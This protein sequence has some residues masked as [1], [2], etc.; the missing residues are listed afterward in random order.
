MDV[1]K[2]EDLVLIEEEK[3]ARLWLFSVKQEKLVIRS[4]KIKIKS[5]K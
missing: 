4:S 1:A 2:I 3:L 5:W